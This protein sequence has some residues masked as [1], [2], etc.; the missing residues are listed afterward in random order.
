[1]PISLLV[2]VCFLSFTSF[3]GSRVLMSLFALELG[4]SGA[5]VGVLISLYALFPLLLSIVAGRVVDRAG[6]FQPVLYGSAGFAGALLIPFF[7]PTLA[8]LYA[9][10]T[11]MGLSLVFF[12]VATQH[13]VSSLGG[14]EER[15]RN[16][17]LYSLGLAL[18]GLS[19]PLLAGYVIDHHGHVPAFLALSVV[20]ILASVLWAVMRGRVPRVAASV[21]APAGRRVAELLRL[22]GLRR[23][24]IV[25]G[26]IVAGIDLFAF[27]MPIYG[28]SI[29][30]SATMIGVVLGAYAVAT[31]LV[32][33]VM[34]FIARR[35]G[36]A[37]V[38]TGSLLVAGI[39]YF[40][41]PFSQHLVV[42]I[43]L[44]FALGVGLGCGQ[45]LSI[46]MVY[47]SAPEGRAGEALGVR[48]TVVN[49][50]H[51]AIPLTFGTMSAALGLAPVFLSNSAL[52]FGGWW[53]SRR[54]KPAGAH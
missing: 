34:P 52:M 21:A 26:I 2:A 31:F 7:V 46:I 37:R 27:Y 35:Y 30:L 19:G 36:E 25:S 38:I 50:M 24:M 4:A 5:A 12:G 42:L 22:P 32:R 9:A 29:G 15:N 44:S 41:L 54:V 43:L 28:H 10:A 6:S 1:M 53:L 47:N 40:V 13:L 48:F 11:L 17:S 16:V 39:A 20:V 23:M 14:P 51:L 49:F 18:T 8:A 3:S 45:P 33:G